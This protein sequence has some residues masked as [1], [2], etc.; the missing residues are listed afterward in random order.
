MEE[1]GNNIFCFLVNFSLTAAVQ[2]LYTNYSF[3]VINT[4]TTEEQYCD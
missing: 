2:Y 3:H 1:H 4:A